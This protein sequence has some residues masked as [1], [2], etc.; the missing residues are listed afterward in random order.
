M[1]GIMTKLTVAD[2]ADE[3]LKVFDLD[4]YSL[5][6]KAVADGSAY[7]F[8]N[9]TDPCW[10][11]NFSGGPST[12]TL[13]GTTVAEQDQYLFWDAVHPTA[14]GHEIL[15]DVALLELGVDTPEP[16]TWAMIILGFAGLGALGAR[17]R[18]VAT[19]V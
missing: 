16:S 12:A 9:V 11:G 6:D 7:G 10:T 5:I 14:A 4:A 17:K 13:C 2:I 18:A 8:T 19:P 1:V 15:S 3:M